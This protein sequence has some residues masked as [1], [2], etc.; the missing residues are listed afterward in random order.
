MPKNGL[1]SIIHLIHSLSFFFVDIYRESFTYKSYFVEML[2]NSLILSL[3]LLL[4]SL[5]LFLCKVTV[6][7]VALYL[8]SSG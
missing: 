7:W 6:H 1:E 4:L 3:L 2:I 5:L 8:L